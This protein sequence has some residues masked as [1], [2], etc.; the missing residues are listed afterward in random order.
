MVLIGV[1]ILVISASFF[2]YRYPPQTW[3]SRLSVNLASLRRHLPAPGN[4]PEIQISDGDRGSSVLSK[5]TSKADQD[6]VLMPPPALPRVTAPNTSS[7]QTTPKALPS[8]H[9]SALSPPTFNLN[10][11]DPDSS[12]EDLPPPS[13]PALNSAQRASAPRPPTLKPLP[14]GNMPAP[15][16]PTP[17]PRRNPAPNLLPNRG[18][19]PSQQTSLTLP[20]SLTVK[21]TKPSRK[22]QLTPGHSPLDWA[23]LTSSPGANLRGDIS[24][25]YLIKVSPS[26]LRKHNKRADAWTVLG[27]K[28][29]NITPYLPFHPG[30]EREL[31]RAAG[32]EGDRLFGEVHPWVNW[33]GMLA[34]CL[35]G[36]AVEEGDVGREGRLEELD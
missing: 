31:M 21:P 16:R 3:L 23:R 11:S 6:R 1:S 7:P 20:P 28:V 9:V 12:D 33:E 22:V 36:V 24:S 8:K 26:L 29:Y 27:G 34:E 5:S 15:P 4:P 13:F 35:V 19:P 17:T 32:G 2:I 25:P 30:G 10:S 18:P 14:N